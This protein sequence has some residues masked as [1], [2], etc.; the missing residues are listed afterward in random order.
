[1]LGQKLP[2]EVAVRHIR[3]E[4]D[5]GSGEY[6]IRACKIGAVRILVVSLSEKGNNTDEEKL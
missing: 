2:S 3:V 6:N 4:K 5:S 1:M